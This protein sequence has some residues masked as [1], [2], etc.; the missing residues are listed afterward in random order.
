MWILKQCLKSANQLFWGEGVECLATLRPVAMG[1]HGGEVCFPGG[2]PEPGDMN[3]QGTAER[4][5][6][7][8][9]GIRP[10][11]VLGELSSI[12]L[13]TSDYRIQPYV[14]AIDSKAL[15]PNSAEVDKALWFSVDAIF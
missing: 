5:L 9:L 7:E 3:L 14:C 4:E 12:P 13:F 6:L 15:A 11:C 8:E 2:K 1:E 10:S